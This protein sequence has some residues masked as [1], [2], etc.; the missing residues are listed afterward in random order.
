MGSEGQ[1]STGRL[2]DCIFCGAPARSKEHF[3]PAALGGTRARSGTL[4]H[5]CNQ[6]FSRLDSSLVK[7]IGFFAALLGVPDRSRSPRRGHAYDPR[8]RRHYQFQFDGQFESE[9][10]EVQVK[11]GP[12][13]GAIIKALGSAKHLAEFQAKTRKHFGDTQPEHDTEEFVPIETRNRIRYRSRLFR[14][15]SARILLNFLADQEPELARSP[16]LRPLKTFITTGRQTGPTRLVWEDFGPDVTGVR[17]M[18]EFQHRILLQLPADDGRS[19]GR[20][21]WF[22]CLAVAV[23]LA[24]LRGRE[25]SY[26]IDVNPFLAAPHGDRRQQILRGKLPAPVPDNPYNRTALAYR[27]HGASWRV[28]AFNWKRRAQSLLT[29][30]NTTRRLSRATRGDAIAGLLVKETGRIVSMLNAAVKFAALWYEQPLS[31]ADAKRLRQKLA[32]SRG[33]RYELSDQTRQLV[34][35]LREIV[36][37]YLA[38]QLTSRRLT[39]TALQNL[40]EGLDG[41]THAIRLLADAAGIRKPELDLD[42][43]SRRSRLINQQISLAARAS[44]APKT[45]G[46]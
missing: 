26:L 35:S 11:K 12:E 38:D 7:Q 16:T 18:T 32:S 8:L 41:G 20:I 42:A 40:F 36:S 17:T 21:I 33:S 44:L 2:K 13:G 45:F 19:Y 27:F 23:D 1:V 9:A 22:D 43:V 31:A 29:D 28:Q 14:R 30:L 3:Y 24:R 5:P 10:V 15:A 39:L 6:K 34:D 37:E 4:C 46:G 25:A